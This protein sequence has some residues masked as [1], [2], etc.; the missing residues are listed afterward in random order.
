MKGAEWL[1]SPH[2]TIIRGN[3]ITR[4]YFSHASH[5]LNVESIHDSSTIQ[6]PVLQSNTG[7]KEK[8]RDNS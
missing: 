2:H 3:C 5:R 6:F 8:Y 1:D 4:K 7:K